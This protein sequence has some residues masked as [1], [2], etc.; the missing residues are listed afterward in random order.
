MRIIS[1]ILISI[2]FQVWAFGQEQIS[3]PTPTQ[4]IVP[5]SPT[6]AALGK[7]GEI[8]VGHYTGIPNISVPLCNLS[9]KQLSVPISMSY[10]ASGIKV[11]EVA[12]WVGLGWSLTAGGVISKSVRGL[13]D[14]AG[15]GYN[16]NPVLGDIEDGVLDFFNNPD[17]IENMANG[18]ADGEI[19]VYHFN[20][21]GYSGK[22]VIDKQ[23]QVHTIPYQDIR[24]EPQGQN[25]FIVTTPDGNRFVF[26]EEET[27]SSSSDCLGSSS[28]PESTHISAWYLSRIE[29]GNTNDV[30]TFNYME[31]GVVSYATGKSQTEYF[32]GLIGGTCK[33]APEDSDC[34]NST[35]TNTKKISS[36]VSAYGKIE[37]NSSGG[38]QD[39][40]ANKLDEILVY[41]A[42]LNT[43]L[44]KWT[45]GYDYFVSG[46]GASPLDKRLK[47]ASIQELPGNPA[48]TNLKP[49]YQFNYLDEINDDWKLPSRLSFAQD[50]WGFYNGADGN[51]SLL[52]TGVFVDRSYDGANRST[53]EVNTLAG[54]LNKITY[55]TGGYTEFEFEAN[56]ISLSQ[57]LADIFTS[58]SSYQ[59][60]AVSVDATYSGGPVTESTTFTLNQGVYVTVVIVGNNVDPAL[61]W[62]G[63]VELVNE[64]GQSFCDPGFNQPG[65]PCGANVDN[66]GA[67]QSIYFLPE[68]T[69]T[70]TATASISGE[71]S[72]FDLSWEEHVRTT[73]VASQNDLVEIPVG[74]A[75]IKRI[76]NF[77]GEKETIKRY[78]YQKHQQQDESSGETISFPNYGFTH[79]EYRSTFTGDQCPDQECFFRALSSS[80]K[81]ALGTSQGSHVNY[82]EVTVYYGE[83]GEAGKSEYKYTYADDKGGTGYPYSNQTSYDW[84][85]GHLLVQR[86]YEADNP[87]PIH[88]VSNTY[89]FREDETLNNN[90]ITSL[91]IGWKLQGDNCVYTS[92]WTCS[93]EDV[94]TVYL[95]NCEGP[96]VVIFG[97]SYLNP[98]R[99]DTIA[100][101]PCF[102]KLEGTVINNTQFEN[103]FSY[104]TFETISQ[105]MQLTSTT[106]V[107][108]GVSVTTNFEYDDQGRHTLPVSTIMANSDGKVYDTR[109]T[110]TA[111]AIDQN[112]P[113]AN[114][115]NGRFMIYTPF[116]QELFVD[117]A[118]QRG[119]LTEYQNFN[120]KY[121]PKKY[122]ELL[123]DNTTVERGVISNYDID[124]YILGY[125][126][127][128]F[129]EE[130][131]SWENGLVKTKTYGS[132]VNSYD[133]YPASRL[134]QS[135][136]EIDGQIV[137]FNYDG[138]Q[139]LLSNSARFGNV[140]NSFEYIYGSENLIRSTTTTNDAPEQVNIQYF[141]ALGRP[142]KSVINGVVKNET[143]YDNLG[144]VDKQTYLPGNF[145]QM[146]YDNSPLNRIKEQ[147]FPDGSS[148]LTSYG[149]IGGYFNVVNTDE[150]GNSTETQTDKLGRIFKIIN[151]L[152]DEMTYAYDNRSN[153]LTVT[154][155]DGGAAGVYNYTYDNRNRLRTKQIPG[156]TGD[157]VYNYFD[158]TD[159]MRSTTDPNGT[160]VHMKYDIYGRETT[161]H[162]NSESGNTISAQ[163]Y[164]EGGIPINIG[165]LT[166]SSIWVLN[167]NNPN[168]ELVTTF[169]YDSYGRV[170][171][172]TS[173]NHV[174]GLDVVTNSY[175]DLDWML[176]MTRAH[177]SSFTSSLNIAQQYTY[178]VFG[179]KL[180]STHQINGGTLVQLSDNSYN[181]RDQLIE[182]NIGGGLQSCDYRYNN[183]GWLTHMNQPTH[184][185]GEVNNLSDL[186]VE[187]SFIDSDEFISESSIVNTEQLTLEELLTR[188][189]EPNLTVGEYDVCQS[190]CIP[191]CNG[192]I[193]NVEALLN[194]LEDKY[195]VGVN[196]AG[197][198]I[199]EITNSNNTG[200]A[201]YLITLCNGERYYTFS[202][203]WDESLVSGGT[204]ITTVINNVAIGNTY[205]INLPNGES[206]AVTHDELVWM[207]ANQEPFIVP[208]GIACN[209]GC[210]NISVPECDASEQ[211][212]YI[213]SLKDDPILASDVDAGAILT[214]V[215]LCD[216]SEVYLLESELANLPGEHTVLQTVD[217]DE[218]TY[219]TETTIDE[220][221]RNDLFHLQLNYGDLTTSFGN[222]KNGNISQMRW[223][224]AGRD[225][226]NYT[227]QYDALDRIKTAEYSDLSVNAQG[228]IQKSTTNSFGVYGISYDPIGNI[229]T[230]N[231]R[232]LYKQENCWA[233]VEIDQMVYSYN[234]SRLQNINDG[235]SNQD[236]RALGFDSRG[237]S[238]TYGYD[239]NGNMT[240]DPYKQLEIAYNFINLPYRI[241]N[242]AN[243]AQNITFVYNAGGTKLRKTVTGGDNPCSIDYVGGIEYRDGAIEAIYHEG[244]RAFSTGEGNFR[245]EYTIQ[246]H[247]GNARLQF[248]DLNEDGNI[249]KETEILQENH[250][251]PF[252]L[253][254]KGPWI[255]TA[256]EENK[257]Q[258]NGKELQEDFGLNWIDY[259]ARFYDPSIGRWHSVDPLAEKYSSISPYAYVVNNPLKFI[260]PDGKRVKYAKDDKTRADK[261]KIKNQIRNLR[262]NSETFNN[263]YKILKK[264]KI[265][266]HT[267]RSVDENNLGSSDDGTS[268][269]ETKGEQST[270]GNSSEIGINLGQNEIEGDQVPNSVIMGHEFA[271]AFRDNQGLVRLSKIDGT[272]SL[273]DRLHAQK[274]QGAE[275]R[276]EEEVAAS[277]IENKI[278][279]EL[280]PSG[281]I[282]PRRSK[283]SN[284]EKWYRSIEMVDGKM[285]P[286]LK[287]YQ[288][289]ELIPKE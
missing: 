69:Y 27:T 102:E 143:I 284:L 194:A 249:D 55:P 158:E 131:Y 264:D 286:T 86:D 100:F 52:P 220:A 218:P 57:S 207:V 70:M 47:L 181:D 18:I 2:L 200:F 125:K 205:D 39:E 231:R 233:P 225:L 180:T 155:P 141:D 12:S 58:S 75:R 51:T 101:H 188:R 66:T 25:G 224:V 156:T 182:K 196:S 60:R 138:Y 87:N 268:Y 45:F 28:P 126:Y 189:F 84:K 19:D 90:S 219:E 242:T 144:R 15:L 32:D 107:T 283:Y 118:L 265:H 168:E 3:V 223:Q 78:S 154:P 43:V 252:G 33:T 46:S 272:Q 31:E 59:E 71:S 41:G 190:P 73:N 229:K 215:V 257:Y 285:T 148:T 127:M 151:P 67:S 183:R 79:G 239:S 21:S 230:L 276:A 9:G 14:G 10:H 113:L 221:D 132:W 149:G 172:T 76:T 185:F 16:N 30:I 133:Y 226:Q 243:T 275:I 61:E 267:I 122:L 192:A 50:H 273:G 53:N 117:N 124:G 150:N 241:Q 136:T 171:E 281:K 77:D 157:H 72:Q 235:V 245:Y 137:T 42:D 104:R 23:N 210:A 209:A 97:G 164:D 64:D 259:G 280:D 95:G 161:R 162:L 191:D 130:V 178:D 142:V 253:A 40:G 145:T 89:D 98:N 176:G 254:M 38:R 26:E 274:I 173:E 13:D 80:S 203:D 140:S 262:R 49:P 204:T 20:F 270:A 266:T 244:G 260:D 282:I 179:R 91:K 214:R 93:P 184:L 187:P 211:W 6:A 120:G 256:G 115:M 197:C 109:M 147:I 8:P 163:R 119:V 1:I 116:K 134:V 165:K 278:R 216:G 222:Y 212:E 152:G 153:L 287:V 110:Y 123:N 227:Y 201:L 279:N 121:L 56:S 206:R 68:G 177:S 129:P 213:H 217:L 146:V 4:N 128:D 34:T 81:A 17:W 135:I 255:P 261:R 269:N 103:R 111:D 271:H 246:D 263:M 29:H 48:N 88:T 54:M 112:L 11:D 108:D 232:G 22:F 174:G 139:R 170:G 193:P 62:N 240:S 99:C 166:S 208:T 36:I 5:P 199:D 175:N 237:N 238:G 169:D 247:L 248:A 167:G 236:H 63:S 234:G 198:E 37:F 159:L 35:I 114:E 105:W 288:Y 202:S 82:T 258:Y 106:E 250:Y 96:N 289:D 83:N 65:V 195:L 228:R 94:T 277:I 44:K 74:G 186:C 85:R 160:T 251:Y 24:I 7:Y 92:S